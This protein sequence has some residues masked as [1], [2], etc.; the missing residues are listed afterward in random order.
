MNNGIFICLN[1]AGTHRGFGVQVSFVRSLE[2]DNISEVQ[3][4]MLRYGGNRQFFQFLCLYGLEREPLETRYFTKACQL[5]RDR[6]KMMAEL[7]QV[8]IFNKDLHNILPIEEGKQSIYGVR[9]SYMF[10]DANAQKIFHR[11]SEKSQPPPTNYSK[12]AGDLL[13]N[14]KSGMS[15]VGEQLGLLQ[16][17][18]VKQIKM[19]D[20]CNNV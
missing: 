5:Y 19:A 17:Y 14:T 18:F 1:C 13:E 9:P 3:N 2:M 4:L 10:N 16:D 6:L 20:C 15:K 8:F 11:D 12:M 7:N